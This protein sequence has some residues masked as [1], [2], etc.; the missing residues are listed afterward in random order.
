MN[1]N[2]TNPSSPA[3]AGGAAGGAAA[4]SASSVP[5][6]VDF[7]NPSSLNTNT[8]SLSMDDSLASAQDNL[9]SAGQAANT[10]ASNALGLDQLDGGTAGSVD[11]PLGALTPAEPVPGSIGSVTSVPPLAPTPLDMSAFGESATPTPAATPAPVPDAAAAPAPAAPASPFAGAPAAA[12]TTPTTPATAATT[13][14]T[15]PVQPYYNPFA[16]TMGGN[17]PASSTNVPPALQPQTEKFSNSA[18]GTK[19]KLN[20][21]SLLGWIVALIFAITTVVFL[22]FWLDAKNNPEVIYRDPPVPQEPVADTVSLMTCV[23]DYGNA[24]VEGLEELV[25]QRKESSLRFVNG[26]LNKVD[27]ANIFTF[28]DDETAANSGWYFEEQ[29]NWY[30]TIAATLG[31]GAITADINIDGA[32]ARQTLSATGENL[33]GEYIGI[34]GLTADEAGEVNMD[35]E[36]IRENYVNNGFICTAE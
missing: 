20:I 8:S 27:L 36:A 7:T 29:R 25:D 11:Q 14:S 24:Y 1:P 28:A 23:Q 31:V 18:D 26:V 17:T 6:P 34:F 3:S 2:E 16:R 4:P 19:K 9:T 5:S 15:K 12:P 33:L 13:P 30:S 10:G 21:S 35:E 32:T 22:M